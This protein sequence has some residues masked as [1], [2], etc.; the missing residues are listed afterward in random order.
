MLANINNRPSIEQIYPISAF[1]VDAAQNAKQPANELVRGIRIL[2]VPDKDGVFEMAR[3][4]KHVGE[5]HADAFLAAYRTLCGLHM[6]AASHQSLGSNPGAFP[7]SRIGQPYALMNPDPRHEYE[8]FIDVIIVAASKV[9]FRRSDSPGR[10][11]VR[12]QGPRQ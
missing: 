3:G 8:S 9:G 12:L 7:T 6:F 4:T 11:D 10:D 1:A 2:S 5:V